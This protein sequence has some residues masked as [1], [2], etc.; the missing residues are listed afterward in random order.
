M[1]AQVPNAAVCNELLSDVLLWNQEGAR[2]EDVTIRL[3]MHT[4]YTIHNWIDGKY[5]CDKC[6]ILFN[7]LWKDETF[8]EKLW[9]IIAQLK[10]QYQ[11][12]FWSD[13]GV[14]FKVLQKCIHKLEWNFVNVKV[15]FYKYYY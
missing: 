12:N 6:T 11:I 2:I 9:S 5:T 4:G 1:K 3:R 7:I 14:Q 13:K 8:V 10:Y 15:I